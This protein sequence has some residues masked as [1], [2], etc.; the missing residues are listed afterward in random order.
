MLGGFGRIGGEAVLPAKV[1]PYC[2]YDL[3]FLVC[4][5]LLLLGDLLLELFLRFPALPLPEPLPLP[6]A[7]PFWFRPAFLPL[8]LPWF[9]L[10]ERLRLELLQRLL[11]LRERLRP[12]LLLT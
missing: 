6:P 5:E 2:I 9:L 11:L 4:D 10:L 7:L 1:L 3:L 12:R 8:P